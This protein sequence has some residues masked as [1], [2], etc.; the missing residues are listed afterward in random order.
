MI[1]K[2]EHAKIRSKCEWFQHGENPTKLF[3]NLETK[4]LQIQQKDT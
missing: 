1:K 3:L 2:A 4:K